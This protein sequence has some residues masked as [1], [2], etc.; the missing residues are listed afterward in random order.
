MD[1]ES[2]SAVACDAVA[3]AVEVV[4]VRAHHA[5]RSLH[6]GRAIAAATRA[7]DIAGDRHAATAVVR[8]APLGTPCSHGDDPGGRCPRDNTT[9]QSLA[10]LHAINKRQLVGQRPDACPASGPY[11]GGALGE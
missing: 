2:D 8:V 3:V 7:V 9:Y 11:L 6:V 4:D 10:R 1:L 5:N